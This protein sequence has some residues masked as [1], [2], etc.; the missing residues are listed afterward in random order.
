[1]LEVARA[2]VAAAG[3]EARVNFLCADAATHDFDPGDADLLHSR[4]G[5]M[6]FDDPIA[7]FA[8]LRRAMKRT[9]RLAFVCWQD[10]SRNEWKR[11][12]CAA[13]MNL[14]PPPAPV[15]PEAP[16][17]ASFASVARIER[18]LLA[19]G[20]QNIRVAPFQCEV[21]FGRTIDQATEGAGELALGEPLAAATADLR[22]RALAAVRRALEPYAGRRGVV[23]GAAAWIVTAV[24]AAP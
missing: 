3:F 4:F 17:A 24:A 10:D 13:A 22:E 23:L 2:R 18:V 12:P 8:N 15:D 16:G 11:V 5:V 20:W 6:F 7:A 21:R 19:A 1:M 9:G 14:L